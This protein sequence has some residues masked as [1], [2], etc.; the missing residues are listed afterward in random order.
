MNRSLVLISAILLLALPCFAGLTYTSTS[1]V[2][3][4]PGP[5]KMKQ[6]M[7]M[8]AW[9]SGGN[10]KQ[11][12]LESGS[13][14]IPSGSYLLKRAD[15]AA[16][17]LVNPA[18]KTYSTWDE[19]KMMD[20]LRSAVEKMMKIEDAHWEKV[21]EEDGGEVSGFPTKH[22]HFRFT[23]TIVTT[24]DRQEAHVPATMEQ[25]FWVTDKVN[26]PGLEALRTYQFVQALAGLSSDM[27]EMVRAEMAEMSG[28]PVKEVWT[29]KAAVD[30][31]E[32]TLQTTT[33]TISDIRSL[34]VPESVFDIP[35]NFSQTLQPA[36]APN[37]QNANALKQ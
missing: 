19:E 28:F 29:V 32:Q 33:T 9:I 35:K 15:N 3:S 17:L 25:E 14:D 6:Q 21:S 27:E 26:D 4:G 18:T 30:D 24:V 7:R 13:P 22:Y 36:L 11:Q 20:G 12:V 8:Q 1:T 10:A 5:V 2:E 31:G 23:Y 34:D 37:S 16:M